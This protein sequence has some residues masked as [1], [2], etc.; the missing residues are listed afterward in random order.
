MSIE[1]VCGSSEAIWMEWSEEENSFPKKGSLIGEIFQTCIEWS[2]RSSA[3]SKATASL[4]AR[5][6]LVACD[7]GRWNVSANVEKNDQGATRGSVDVKV[8]KQTE[9]GI[10]YTVNAA[11]EARQDRD[12]K[13]ETGVSGSVSIGGKF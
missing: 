7:G 13:V 12:Q 4:P 5:A 8:E 11:V 1:E 2:Q 6:H 3:T 10:E 9:S